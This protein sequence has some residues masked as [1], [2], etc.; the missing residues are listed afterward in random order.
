MC[1]TV[2]LNL[3]FTMSVAMPLGAEPSSNSRL[4]QAAITQSATGTT[5]NSQRS[6][7]ADYFKSFAPVNALDM[8]ER[9]PGFTLQTASEARG[10]GQG[11]AN[12]LVNGR[13]ING[14]GEE[15]LEQLVN[16][17][18]ESVTRLVILDGETLSIPGLSG[19]VVNLITRSNAF[20]G[21]WRWTP[22]WR[23]DGNFAPLRGAVSLVTER[24]EWNLGLSLDRDQRRDLFTGP[25]TLTAIDGTL[26]ETREEDVTIR[27]DRPRIILTA[28]RPNKGSYAA[29]I[30]ASF[31]TFDF[32]RQQLSDTSAVTERG[33]N[34]LNDSLF[35][36][37]QKI[38]KL[39]ADFSFPLGSGTVKLVGLMD[40]NTSDNVTT[41]EVLEDNIGQITNLRFDED[42]S[43]LELVGRAEYSWSGSDV[44]NWQIAGEFA[45]NR[46]DLGTEFLS[47]EGADITQLI[48]L[49]SL[50]DQVE[51][52]RGEASVAYSN[53]LTSKLTL[54]AS[55]SAEYST[56]EQSA[57]KRNFIRP[58]GFVS[59][60]YK[61]Q[62]SWTLSARVSRDVGQLQFRD[63]LA[64]VSLVEEFETAGN[65]NLVPP[66]SWTFTGRAEKRFNDGHVLSAEVGHERITDLVDR[67]PVGD[68]GDAVGNIDSAEVSRLTINGTFKGDAYGVKG[69]QVDATAIFKKSSLTDPIQTFTRQINDLETRRYRVDIRH[70][71]SGTNWAYGA[72]ILESKF[73]DRFQS[74]IIV[75]RDILPDDNFLF[76]EHKNIFGLIA[77][78]R[79][80]RIIKTTTRFDR[81]IHVGRRDITPIDR[82]ESR[83]RDFSGP[84]IELRFRGTF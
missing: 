12:V 28:T 66:Q 23:G 81:T 35:V 68:D 21:N 67:I 20:S 45:F 9:L 24:G 63:F 78:L 69:L 25:E 54:Q 6:F 39:D 1:R 56:I 82:F 64:S 27:G 13:Q 46:L 49:N 72:G 75:M 71:I 30:R 37:D 17:P 31:Q 55:L 65:P 34:S 76:I 5:Q 62:P 44:S 50:E 51:E 61:P 4:S 8:I 48:L 40:Y 11:G 79:V 73:A 14:K 57:L 36:Q 77:Q 7:N 19:P 22:E 80:S 2:L 60:I 84:I 33:L 29:N 58:K 15:Q 59:L 52:L 18:A 74:N 43:T 32:E 38:A 70:D 10:L 41:V 26:F 42:V 53:K 47:G 16:I 3:C 83:R